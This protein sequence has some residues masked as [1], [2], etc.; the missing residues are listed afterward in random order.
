[1]VATCS[2]GL[3]IQAKYTTSCSTLSVKKVKA[4]YDA[5]LSLKDNALSV[6][7]LLQLANRQTLKQWQCNVLDCNDTVFFTQ[8]IT[9]NSV[10]F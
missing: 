10:K 8:D 7:S 6:A 3:V 9:I 2:N 1:M 4:C 5:N